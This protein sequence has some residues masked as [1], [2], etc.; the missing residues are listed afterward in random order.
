[1][2]THSEYWSQD[3]HS[4]LLWTCTAKHDNDSLYMFPTQ[5]EIYNHIVLQHK[6][7]VGSTQ[8]QELENVS[9]LVSQ[10]GA[11]GQPP[12]S[13]CPLCLFSVEAEPTSGDQSDDTIQTTEGS[14]GDKRRLESPKGPKKRAKNSSTSAKVDRTST[15]W[16]MGVHIADHLHYLMI[17][18]LQLMS[19]MNGS[20]YGEGDTQSVPNSPNSRISVPSDDQLEARLDDLPEELQGPI[21]WSDVNETATD[22]NFDLA[23][24]PDD[25]DYAEDEHG[26]DSSWDQIKPELT[27]ARGARKA[28]EIVEQVRYP[29]D[30]TVGWI[31]AVS[32]EYVAAQLFLDEEHEQPAYV[33][34]NDNND[35]KL[36]KIGENNVVIAVSTYGEYN[37]MSSA[38]A[39]AM[40][41]LRSFPNIRVG[42][43]VGIGGGA[44]SQ[45]HDIR[46]GDIVVSAP[47]DGK[48]GVLQYDF[49]KLY[50][51]RSFQRTDVLNQPPEVL[52][53]AL[54]RLKAQYE[55]NGHSYEE[56]INNILQNKPRLQKKFSRPN[57]SSDRLY[58]SD[59]V[60]PA[61]GSG[62]LVSCG[63]DISK[64]VPRSERTQDEDN[65]KIHYGVIASG[66]Q[67]MRDASVRDKLAAE[68]DILCY[69]MEAAGLMNN[70][71]CL[72]IRGICDYSDSHKNKE[73]QGY[74]AMVA[75]AYARDLTCRIT[76]DRIEA[77]NKTVDTLSGNSKVLKLYY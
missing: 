65:P 11:E 34:P 67:V 64:L 17:I 16:A 10:F 54:N 6:R 50:Q 76:P 5:D 36:G 71:P 39:V 61:D 55:I 58:R 1:M 68:H 2:S 18:S 75:A 47:R 8:D 38:A 70:F 46:L 4:R 49:G 19:A 73:W 43:M 14:H 30:Y 26:V 31:C 25:V 57:P 21:S 22:F 69:E 74:A 35:Y 41:M 13:C 59:F 63:T 42:L 77:G 66:D 23:I 37:R 56:D 40:D 28:D 24:I 53:T 15:S 60:H 7:S 44:P 12:A 72:L 3:L 45:K 33:S 20:S 32:T 62:C 9:I 29:N 51:N 52:Q 48:S 27:G